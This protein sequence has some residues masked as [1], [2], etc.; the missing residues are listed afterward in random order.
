MYYKF[1]GLTQKLTGSSHAAV[2]SPQGLRPGVPAESPAMVFA[3]PTKLVSEN[4]SSVEYLGRNNVNE[5]QKL[6]QTQDGL[7]IHLKRGLS[8][9]LL[10]RT[11][12]A[13]TIGGALYCLVALYMAAQ[14]KKN[15]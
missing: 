4:S 13:L 10:Y 14:P 8:D 1:S 15:N 3:S 12:M 9:K 2:F 11:T 7:P 6:F 5:I